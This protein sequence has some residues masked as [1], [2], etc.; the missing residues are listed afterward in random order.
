MESD[1]LTRKTG[2]SL[3]AS[4][5]L[6]LAATAGCGQAGTST[7]AA[8]VTRGGRA[9][10]S[11][12]AATVSTG[13]MR[14]H[15]VG[16]DALSS[17]IKF[18]E[19]A[20]TLAPPSPTAV[21]VTSAETALSTVQASS[22]YEQSF[23]SLPSTGIEYALFT[24]P[25]DGP[26]PSAGQTFKP[27]YSSYPVWFIEYKNVSVAAEH[28]VSAATTT[29]P[30]TEDDTVLADEYFIVDDSQDTLIMVVTDSL[31][32]PKTEVPAAGAG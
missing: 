27:T 13:T 26:E 21:P 3:I 2:V 31:A 1:P 16:S 5:A 20:L 29:S 25:G 15:A 32:P 19:G 7:S 28:G 9:R 18:G 30:T 24:D 22:L 6:V 12:P 14:S 23:A 10:A 11:T 17:P 8:T 4:V